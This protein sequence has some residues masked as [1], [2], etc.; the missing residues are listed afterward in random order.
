MQKEKQFEGYKE[1]KGKKTRMSWLQN[2]GRKRKE[3]KGQRE[4]SI[5]AEE[6]R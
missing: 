1:G 5:L 3:G 2:E 6:I 4:D